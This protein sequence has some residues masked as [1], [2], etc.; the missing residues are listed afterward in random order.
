MEFCVLCC[1]KNFEFKAVKYDNVYFLASLYF[2][3]DKFK[4]RL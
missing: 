3:K 2:V 4:T 1:S